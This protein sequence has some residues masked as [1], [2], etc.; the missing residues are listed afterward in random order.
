MYTY[1]HVS[2]R[3]Y[4]SINPRPCTYK[5]N[6]SGIKKKFWN[7]LFPY[8]LCYYAA[9]EETG[10]GILWDL[11]LSLMYYK[12]CNLKTYSK[13]QAVLNL[14]SLKLL[15]HSL[16]L[17]TCS[18]HIPAHMGLVSACV[19]SCA[20]STLN[21]FSFNQS[22]WNAKKKR[23]NFHV[24]RKQGNVLLTVRAWMDGKLHLLQ[25]CP[26]VELWPHHASAPSAIHQSGGKC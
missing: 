12:N 3:V 20:L 15:V 2:V 11:T 16:M 25:L 8:L 13:R 5:A 17:E 19:F 18:L 23:N 22:D 4:L 26:K 14:L 21:T 7:A 24:W 6:A 9:S 10:E 1:V